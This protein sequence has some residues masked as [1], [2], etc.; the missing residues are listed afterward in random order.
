MYT[1][2]AA[3]RTLPIG[4]IVKVTDQLNGRS[5]MVCI[6]DRGP[7]R[8][9]RIIDLS[10]AAARQ[11][12]LNSRGVG[13]VN[14]EV[15]SDENGMPLNGDKAWYVHFSPDKARERVGP[16]HVFADAAAMH[17]ALRQA[18][19]EAEVVMDNVNK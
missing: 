3:H 17:E 18:Y 6:T 8:R 2:T 13:A 7:Y 14:L 9:G 16:F 4:T 19:P 5:V 10:Y 15:V 11:I 1:F 12:D